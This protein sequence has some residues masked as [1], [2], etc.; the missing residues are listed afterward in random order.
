MIWPF[1]IVIHY[2]FG[3][4]FWQ[5]LLLSSPACIAKA[6]RKIW[7]VRNCLQRTLMQWFSIQVLGTNNQ[8]FSWTSTPESN[9][10][11]TWSVCH[12]VLQK[13][14]NYLFI[15]VTIEAGKHLKHAGREFWGPWLETTALVDHNELLGHIAFTIK[16]IVE[17]TCCTNL[18]WY[19]MSVRT[20]YTNSFSVF[21]KYWYCSAIKCS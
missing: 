9:E 7:V 14:G 8:M 5:G 1:V 6:V 20:Y 3:I 17:W 12:Q 10:C 13:S 11:I 15:E 4:T 18:Y 21:K 2:V 19:S 16:G